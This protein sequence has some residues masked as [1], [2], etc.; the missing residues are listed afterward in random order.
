MDHETHVGIKESLELPIESIYS[1]RDHR[2]LGKILLE[3]LQEAA[4]VQ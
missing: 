2:V 3:A 1:Y 4:R